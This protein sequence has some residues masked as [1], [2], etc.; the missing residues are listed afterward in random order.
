MKKRNVKPIGDGPVSRV[1]LTRGKYALVDSLYAE[2]VGRYNWYCS[3]LGYAMTG[4]KFFLHRLIGYAIGLD[5]LL[6]IDH[7][8]RDKLDCRAANLRSATRS[9]QAINRSRDN[10]W[11]YRGVS[12]KVEGRRRQYLAKI[13]IKGKKVS[14]GCFFTPQEAAAAYDKAAIENHGEFAVTNQSLGRI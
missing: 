3:K 6:T 9:E 10:K 11:G 13:L 8:N 12:R 1:K 2:L 14:L 4:K 7:V 5:P